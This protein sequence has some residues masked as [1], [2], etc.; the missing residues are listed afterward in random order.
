M[1]VC[2]CVFGARLCVCVLGGRVRSGLVFVHSC[3]LVTTLAESLS[4]Q[5]ILILFKPALS[6]C[7]C[8]SQRSYSLHGRAKAGKQCVPKAEPPCLVAARPSLV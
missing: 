6:S 5:V 1:C 8:A 4:A 7:P 2:V 3:P